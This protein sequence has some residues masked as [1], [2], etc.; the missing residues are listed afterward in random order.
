MKTN[1]A[2]D[3]EGLGALLRGHR[4]SRALTLR[5]AAEEVGVSASTLSRIE[6]GKVRPDL[7]TI[8]ELVRWIGIPLS[9]VVKTP[10]KKKKANKMIIGSQEIRKCCQ[11]GVSLFFSYLTSASLLESSSKA[12]SLLISPTVSKYLPSI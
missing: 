5:Q 10:T 7:P 6:K 1:A 12:V 9:R 2:V 8:Q 4:A 3:W 11:N